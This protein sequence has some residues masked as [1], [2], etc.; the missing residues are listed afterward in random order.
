MTNLRKKTTYTATF[1]WIEQTQIMKR[2][3]N[4]THKERIELLTEIYK[5]KASD[6]V[7]NWITTSKIIPVV[8]TISLKMVKHAL[9]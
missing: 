3:V 2:W 5:K 9:F 1:P 8:G 4:Q 6:N 7:N